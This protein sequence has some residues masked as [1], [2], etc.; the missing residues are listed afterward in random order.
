MSEPNPSAQEKLVAVHKAR[1]EWEAD[2]LVGY[3]R[4]NGID[5]TLMDPPSR[6]AAGFH[7]GYCDPD[8]TCA[9]FV[10]EDQENIARTL[11]GEF[12]AARPGETAPAADAAR[13]AHLDKARIAE[14]RETV[15]EERRTFEFLGWVGVVFL[16]AGALLWTLWPAWLKMAAPGWFMRWPMVLLWVLAALFVS[17]WSGRRFR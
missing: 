6:A 15:K 10:L 14:L 2:L 9:V 17:R 8:T 4:N 3:L 16:A 7:A 1:D 12:L 13:P 11:V 5:A